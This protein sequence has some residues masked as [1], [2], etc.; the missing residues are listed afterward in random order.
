MLN[1]TSA[2]IR[3]YFEGDV[4]SRCL[5]I[6]SKNLSESTR[7]KLKVAIAKMELFLNNHSLAGLNKENDS[8]MD[9]FLPGVFIR[10]KTFAC[11]LRSGLR[12]IGS[13]PAA[14]EFQCRL[15]RKKCCMR[16]ITAVSTVFFYPR[17]ECY[18]EDGRYAYTGQDAIR[19]RKKAGA[20]GKGFN[21]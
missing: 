5:L 20:R 18:S 19:F 14:P 4:L 8:A 3:F 2:L 9:D 12:E 1:H 13:E 16:F 11:L 15:C 7:T 21:D 17:N 10:Y 6:M